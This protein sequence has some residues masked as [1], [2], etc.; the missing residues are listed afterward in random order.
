MSKIRVGNKK[1]SALNGEWAGHVRKDGKRMTSGLRRAES[2][3]ITISEL[4]E[5]LKEAHYNFINQSSL[6]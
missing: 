4:K 5:S 1:N 2:K 6:Y 3:T